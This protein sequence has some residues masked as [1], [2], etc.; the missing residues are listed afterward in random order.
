MRPRS[1]TTIIAT[2]NMQTYMTV[3]EKAT[4]LCAL[5]GVCSLGIYLAACDNGELPAGGK[6]PA[7]V[8]LC[9]SASISDSPATKAEQPP[10]PTITQ[11]NAFS[12]N[13]THTFGMFITRE[14]G[15]ALVDGSNDNMKSTLTTQQEWK[16]FDKNDSPVSLLVNNGDKIKIAGYYPWS[17]KAGVS[18]T[19]VP[20]DLSSTDPKDW[21]DLL[22]LSSPTDLKQITDVTGP[23]AL[24]FSHAFCWVTVNLL[25]LSP[26]NDVR[27]KAVNI[28]NAYAGQGT[29]INKGAIDLKGKVVNSTSGPLKIELASPITLDREGALGATP[30][31]FH[32]LVPP[33][34]R[35]DIKN[36]D[37]VI[38][39][40]TLESAGSGAT[41][42]EKVLTF[43][44]SRSHLNSD[45]A[46]NYGF[47][48][49]KHN[50]YHIV[51]NNSAMNL[52]LS[53][54]NMTTIAEAKLGEGTVNA[55]YVN[56]KFTGVPGGIDYVILG[57]G[58]HQGKTFALTA[59]NHLYH[60]YL[61]EAAENNNG[62]YIPT[63]DTQ[64]KSGYDVRW[65][66]ALIKEP[67]YPN[68]HIAE[69][70]AAGGAR[71]P[72]KDEATGVL[73]A[74]QAC[75]EFRDG[76]FSDW[77][78]PRIS[79]CYMFSYNS[80]L[81]IVTEC[82]SGTEASDTKCYAMV[83]GKNEYW[84][85]PYSKQELFYVRCVRDADKSKPT[86]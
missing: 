21:I 76:G 42:E 66:D 78:L 64:D 18:A 50:T 11:G 47:E 37:I 7:E 22:Y 20:F 59:G 48:K 55:K 3:R 83:K 12:E 65:L 8:E 19:A 86:K 43:P 73:L 69:N 61:G 4:R 5:I 13:T 32:F 30:A 28:G 44:L 14:D 53:D 39:V 49:G 2:V 71:V 60:S 25:Q 63:L 26:N 16:H 10:Y 1:K 33:V 9:F 38:E 6:G 40:T 72:W 74:K 67:V 23:I 62:E 31:V 77:R 70:L 81:N 41:T 75:V 56:R 85:Q 27:V 79:E 24:T 34:M 52:S 35:T 57:L 84:P 58:S 29:I 36:S 68:I 17:P 54:W 15:T 45:A 46:G 51:Y 82:W 80:G